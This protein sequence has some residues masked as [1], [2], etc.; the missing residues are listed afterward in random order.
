MT[1]NI[2][3]TGISTGIG[4]ATGKLLAEKGCRIFGSVRKQADADKVA[5]LLGDSYVPLIFDICDEA[6]VRAAMDKVQRETGDQ[7]LQ[8]LIN[9]AGIAVQGPIEYIDPVQLKHQFDVNVVGLHRLSCACIPF[10]QGIEGR[11]AR[12]INIGSI[13][14][15]FT[16]PFVGTYCISKYALEALSDAFRRELA[17]RDAGIG[18]TL[19]E[20]GAI[21]TPIWEKAKTADNPWPDSPYGPILSNRNSHLEKVQARAI[22]AYRVASVIWNVITGRKKKARYI[23]MKNP[24]VFRLFNALPDALKDRFIVRQY[25]KEFRGKEKN[26]EL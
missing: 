23:V 12:I 17:I 4:L 15:L 26:Y 25:R 5:N 9:N 10:M 21:L 20:P 16:T 3:I 6:A 8:V 13:S 1:H 22:P 11:D 18:V 24:L 2:L 19:I 7:G 14:G